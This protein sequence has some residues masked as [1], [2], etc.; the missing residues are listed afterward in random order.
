MIYNSWSKTLADLFYYTTQ[1]L[2]IDYDDEVLHK[3]RN[4]GGGGVAAVFAWFDCDPTNC[5]FNSDTLL[6]SSWAIH[7]VLKIAEI[8]KV[9]GNR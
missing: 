2:R 3:V 7:T 1:K 4:G 9:V 5:R 8:A 6:Y